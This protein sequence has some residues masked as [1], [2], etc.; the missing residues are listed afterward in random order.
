M[1]LR[2][3]IEEPL[4]SAVRA[5]EELLTKLQIP[6][7]FVGEV[8]LGA[9]LGRPAAAGAV[10]VLA[11]LA[12][13]R[14]RQVPMMASNRGFLVDE[15]E[16]EGARELDL[17]P[18]RFDHPAGSPRVHVLMASNAL[19]SRMLQR[20]SEAELGDDMIPV[21]HPED[22]GLMLAMQDARATLDA[23][24]DATGD[25]F[26]RERFDRTLES[27]GLGGRILAR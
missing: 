21:A 7:A 11:L 25:R 13:D 26:D 12:P 10:D 9:W 5:T 27:I 8:A 15:G 18:M 16:V 6:H 4:L 3:E 2:C 17:I 23:L 22:L 1:A 14:S 24:I 20:T 19:Y